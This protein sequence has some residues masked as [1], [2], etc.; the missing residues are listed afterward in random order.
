M[1]DGFDG[2]GTGTFLILAF[3]VILHMKAETGSGNTRLVNLSSNL[4][5]LIVFLLN[6][7][8]LIPLGLVASLFSIAGHYVGSGM[9]IKNGTKVVRPIIIIVLCILFAKILWE[10]I[11]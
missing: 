1:D 2:H 9:V 11:F 10:I 4:S 3:T 8:V 5:A 7:S 6:G